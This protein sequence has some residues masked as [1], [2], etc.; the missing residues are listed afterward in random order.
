[1]EDFEKVGWGVKEVCEEVI[2]EL[3]LD[4]YVLAKKQ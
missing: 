4:K 3:Q 1:M 2:D